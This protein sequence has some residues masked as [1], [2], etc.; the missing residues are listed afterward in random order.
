M[1]KHMEDVNEDRN[2]L[3]IKYGELGNVELTSEEFEKLKTSLGEQNTLLLIGELDLYIA[4]NPAKGKKYASHYAVIKTW[5][6][7][8]VQEH[9]EKLPAKKIGSV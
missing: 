4:T 3:S 9:V 2:V 5:A 1:P 7:R 8:R 6:R